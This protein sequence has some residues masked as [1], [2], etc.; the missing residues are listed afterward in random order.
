ML[1]Y[2]GDDPR[3]VISGATPLLNALGII[4][5]GWLMALAS[6]I[7]SAREN[8]EDFYKIKINTARFYARH[9]LPQATASASS[10]MAG[11]DEIMALSADAF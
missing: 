6:N 11:A 7:A 3:A 10:A 9:I 4:T 8:S 5:G 2:D 1:A